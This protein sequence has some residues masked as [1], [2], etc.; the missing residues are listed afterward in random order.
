MRPRR[1]RELAFTFTLDDAALGLA[2]E[3]AVREEAAT[4]LLANP[5]FLLLLIHEGDMLN[6]QRNPQ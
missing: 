1:L 2:L 3:Y 4:V 6:M 5:L